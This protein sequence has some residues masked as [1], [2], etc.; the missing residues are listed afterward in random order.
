MDGNRR[1]AQEKKLGKKSEGHKKGF[2]RLKLTLEWCLELGVNIVTVFA[3]AIE[4]FNRE[5]QEVDLLMDLAKTKLREM[6]NEGEFLEYH[7]IK[8]NIIGDLTLL[9][10]DVL[11]AME[12][13]MEITKNYKKMEFNICFAYNSS[14]EINQSLKKTQE[15]LQKQIKEND[16]QKSD[17]S[18]NDL[19]KNKENNQKVNDSPYQIFLKNLMISQPPDIIIRTSNE[20]RLSNF[21]IAQSTNSQL[22][23]IKENWPEISIFSI[24]SIIIQ[25]Q[26]NEK[27]LQAQNQKLKD[28]IYNI[29]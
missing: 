18:Q 23:F 13:I 8:V 12:E 5:Q 6:A 29:A 19:I 25:F 24:L 27:I 4:N 15:T 14:F 28:I 11:K 3:F 26:L 17:N 16:Q 21:L 10:K 1:Y 9:P 20:I 22:Q 2:E 7:Q